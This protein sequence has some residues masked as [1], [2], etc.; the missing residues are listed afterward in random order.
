MNEIAILSKINYYIT[1]SGSIRILTADIGCCYW[2]NK[3]LTNM[4]TSIMLNK[5]LRASGCTLA[6]MTITE[7]LLVSGSGF[8]ISAY[9]GSIVPSSI[10]CVA[11]ISNND[12]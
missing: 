5:I 8:A 11:K 12:W 7:R 9:N 6:L 4:D 1:A 10:D 3:L 2:Y